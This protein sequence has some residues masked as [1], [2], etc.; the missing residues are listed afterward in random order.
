M[1]KSLLI[2]LSLLC[3]PSIFSPSFAMGDGDEQRDTYTISIRGLDPIEVTEAL[4]NNA[5]GCPNE[6]SIQRFYHLTRA[7][8]FPR[9]EVRS[10]LARSKDKIDYLGGRPLKLS[11][12]E[13]EKIS[14]VGYDNSHGM[15][16]TAEVIN[17]LRSTGQKSLIT[18]SSQETVEK[19]SQTSQS[20]WNRIEAAQERLKTALKL[21]S[22]PAELKKAFEEYE[23]ERNDDLDI[24]A[25][26]LLSIDPADP[27]GHVF[28][29]IRTIGKKETSTSTSTGGSSSPSKSDTGPS[30]DGLDDFWRSAFKN[31]RL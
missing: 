30:E 28:R 10:W 4:W 11:F 21:Q 24:V 16:R 31:K 27:V 14:F 13:D 29:Q 19:R 22:S 23:E 25:S 7:A 26:E 6:P 15:G 2:S 17:R 8:V 12:Y 5:T 9:E 1:K 20:S 18:L 3:L